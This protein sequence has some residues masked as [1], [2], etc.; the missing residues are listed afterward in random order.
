MIKKG[1]LLDTG[2]PTQLRIKKIDQIHT[3]AAQLLKLFETYIQ[4]LESLA[5][6]EKN[7]GDELRNF[8]SHDTIYADTI[9]KTASFV[10]YR[11]EIISKNA[12]L[13]KQEMKAAK[14]IDK[15]FNHLTPF[16]RSYLKSFAKIDHYSKKVGKIAM[17]LDTE[18]IKKGIA[19]KKTSKRLIRNQKKLESSKTTSYVSANNIVEQTNRLN[20]ERFDR[21]NPLVSQFVSLELAISNI[22]ATYSCELMGFKESLEAK[23]DNR[24]NDT[25][26]INIPSQPVNTSANRYNLAKQE[27]SAR[28]QYSAYSYKQNVQNNYYILNDDGSKQ[29]AN[30][31]AYQQNYNHNEPISETL[32]R[33]GSTSTNRLMNPFAH[34]SAIEGP[35]RQR[36]EN[37]LVQFSSKEDHHFEINSN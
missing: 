21:F 36:T 37:Q 35:K 9:A 17:D 25:F 34:K 22:H 19:S 27:S 8:Y 26:F 30:S 12:S 18:K 13:L 15:M 6:I 24:F 3:S 7:I 29:N 4:G 10:G 33:D 23:M 31:M 11:S 16:V 1:T 20:L 32:L 2:N 5:N 14:G 28:Q